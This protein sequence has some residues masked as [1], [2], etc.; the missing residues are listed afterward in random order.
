MKTS[1][2]FV[3]L[4]RLRKFRL[5]KLILLITGA[6]LG[7]SQTAEAQYGAPQSYRYKTLTQIRSDLHQ[8]FIN[9][10]KDIPKSSIHEYDTSG[11]FQTKLVKLPNTPIQTTEQLSR[12]G[13]KPLNASK[14]LRFPH[15]DKTQQTGMEG[16]NHAGAAGNF[17]VK[18]YPNPTGGMVYFRVDIDKPRDIIL[19][20][21]NASGGMLHQRK[22]DTNTLIHLDMSRWAAGSYVFQFAAGKQTVS[23]KV[24][25]QK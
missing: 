14:T 25:Y 11:I 16:V 3:L 9:R 1:V 5:N 8:S 20:V 22:I 10:F 17:H 12:P 2:L 19:Y 4:K 7:F 21:F 15:Y 13:K 24:I 18:L 6:I 23:K